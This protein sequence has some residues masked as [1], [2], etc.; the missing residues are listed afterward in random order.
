MPVAA[1]TRPDVV[2]AGDAV[3]KEE[4]VVVWWWWWGRKRRRRRRRGHA[5]VLQELAETLRQSIGDESVRM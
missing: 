3:A 4:V 5:Y 1:P 2:L